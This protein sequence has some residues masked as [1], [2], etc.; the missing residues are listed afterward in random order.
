MVPWDKPTNLTRAWCVWEI[1]GSVKHDVPVEICI[2]PEEDA[3]FVDTLIYNVDSIQGIIAGLDVSKAEAFNPSDRD[4]ILEAIREF[5][6]GVASVNDAVLVPFR[7]WI[8]KKTAEAESE[9]RTRLEEE[10]NPL[11]EAAA[12]SS[13]RRPAST[14]AAQESDP[15][16]H[17]VRTDGPMGRLKSKSLAGQ[18]VA[19]WPRTARQHQWAAA[20]ILTITSPD[21][22]KVKNVKENGKQN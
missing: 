22:L 12:A 15:T 14:C 1:A 3:K 19:V 9:F 20:P 11:S 4:N 21:S 2:P 8:L 16:L 7:D 13:R 18:C 10:E 5:E 17:S 6:G